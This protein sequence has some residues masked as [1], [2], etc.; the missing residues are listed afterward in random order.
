MLYPLSYEVTPVSLP[1]NGRPTRFCPPRISGCK[2]DVMLFH[3]RAELAAGRG[4]SPRSPGSRPGILLL[5]DPAKAGGPP[6]ICTLLDRLRA[7]GFASKLA[8]RIGARGGI[9]TCTGGAL[10]AV[11]LLLGYTSKTGESGGSCTHILSLKGRTL[12]L[13]ELPTRHGTPGE[14]R[15]R[16][17]G[18]K[19]RR[20]THGRRGQWTAW[21]ADYSRPLQNW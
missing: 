15:T 3:H 5:D 14:T 6:G 16:F 2:P 8:D 19:V 13:V 9:R 1:Q 7:D 12:F 18:L 20:P 10:D 17:F 4:L 11:P 21:K